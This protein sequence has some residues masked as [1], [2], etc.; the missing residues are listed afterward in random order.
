M[1]SPTR[2]VGTTKTASC[3]AFNVAFV[4]YLI[5][6][7]V[8]AAE[9]NAQIPSTPGTAI[10]VGFCAAALAFTLSKV[11]LW[12]FS[13]AGRCPSH[14]P[15]CVPPRY[16]VWLTRRY[17]TPHP[18]G[19]AWGLQTLLCISTTPD[20]TPRRYRQLWACTV[21]FQTLW[22]PLLPSEHG[23]RRYAF[24]LQWLF[25]FRPELHLSACWKRTCA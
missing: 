3:G 5:A 1:A 2:S 13:R 9:Q 16:N 12:A 18:T 7:M 24:I 11:A 17:H 22:I 15:A 23:L 6:M 10:G 14:S 19:L 21:P 25:I 8:G 4:A 20:D